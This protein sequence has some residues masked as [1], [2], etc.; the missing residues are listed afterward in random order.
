[1]I[2]F[3]V[4][5]ARFFRAVWRSLKHERAA[6]A[7][8]AFV[9]LILLSGTFFYIEV[10]HWSPIDALYYCVNLLAT[11]G[12]GDL[13]PQTDLGKVFSIIYL[14]MGVGAVLTTL[15]LIAKH[16]LADEHDTFDKLHKTLTKK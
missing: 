6:R 3:F 8:L 16:A 5:I 14:F 9:V 2:D 11:V 7:T 12:T 4:M 10:E 13:R 1:M 15:Q